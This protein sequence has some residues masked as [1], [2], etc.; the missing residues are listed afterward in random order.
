MRLISPRN[1]DVSW[2]QV[3]SNRLRAICGVFVAQ[4]EEEGENF[5]SMPIAG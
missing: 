4:P 3:C 2:L 5:T 1:G